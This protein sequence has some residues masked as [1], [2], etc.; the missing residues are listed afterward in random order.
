VTT[1]LNPKANWTNRRL[2]VSVGNLVRINGRIKQNIPNTVKMYK[3]LKSLKYKPF[4]EFDKMMY[5]EPEE[6]LVTIVTN[7]QNW[8]FDSETMPLAISQAVQILYEGRAWWIF[9]FD[10]SEVYTTLP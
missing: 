10:I 8:E 2:E 7:V 1:T 4:Y 5:I 9:T 6:S 3:S